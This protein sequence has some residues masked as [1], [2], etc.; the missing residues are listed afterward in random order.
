M[1]AD[2]VT[3]LGA[4]AITTPYKGLMHALRNKVADCAITAAM[5]GYRI[6]LHTVTTHVDPVTVS[7]GP[8]IL[9]ANHAAWHRLGQPVRDFLQRELDQLS[10]EIWQAVDRE[11]TVGIACV[12]GNGPCPEGPPGSLK[13]VPV[14]NADREIERKILDGVVLPNWAE[15]CGTECVANWNRTIGRLFDI[16]ITAGG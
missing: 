14:T 8:N 2:F 10:D 11:S 4:T 16:T 3:G 9:I 13:F 5:S 1:H 7:W 6:G 12:T 15:R